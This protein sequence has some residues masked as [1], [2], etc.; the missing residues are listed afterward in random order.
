METGQQSAVQPLVPPGPISHGV[1]GA[2][3]G[4]LLF[5]AAG[6]GVLSWWL[7]QPPAPLPEDAPPEVFSAGRAMQHMRSVAKEPHAA[8]SHALAEVHAY[9][10]ATLRGYGLEVDLQQ[11]CEVQA[12]SMGAVE[13]IV[14]RI[15]G[16]PGGTPFVITTHYDSV[17]SGPG[18]A[19]D[20]SGTVVMLEAARAL[21][22]G[23]PPRNDIVFVFTCDE[24]RMQGGV[25]ACVDHPWVKDAPVVLGF[26]A[27]GVYGPA[28]MFETSDG[29]G[30]LIRALQESGADARTN[31]IMFEV[32]RRTPNSTDFAV[33]KGRGFTGYNVAFVG[34]LYYY[35]TMNDRPELVDPASIQQQGSYAMALARY[36]G[37]REEPVRREE[38]AVYFNTVGAHVVSYP[39]SWSLRIA[40]MAAFLFAAALML[41][42]ALR[43]LTLRGLLFSI[44]AQIAAGLFIAAVTGLLVFVTYKVFYVY[45]LYNVTWYLF[46]FLTFAFGVSAFAYGWAGKRTAP[47]NLHGGALLLWLAVLA[48]LE[49]A[50]PMASFF[51][52]WPLL[53]GSLSLC[54]AV[55]LRACGVGRNVTLPVQVVGA[56]P[57][58]LSLGPGL[59]MLHQIGAAFLLVP[60]TV[61]FFLALALLSPLLAVVMQ[62]RSR[63]VPLACCGTAALLMAIGWATNGFSPLAPKMT[64]LSYALD[65]EKGE[66][67]WLSDDPAPDAWT[68]QFFAHAAAEPTADEARGWARR[69]AGLSAPAPI[70][71]LEGPRL[72]VLGDELRGGGRVLT[73]RYTSPRKAPEAFFSVLPPTRVLAAECEGR[74]ISERGRKGLHFH[75]RVMPWSGAVHFQLKVEPEAAVRIRIEEVSFEIPGVEALGYTPRP[76]WMVVKAN[77]LEWWEGRWGGLSSGCTFVVDEFE[78]PARENASAP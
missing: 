31:S 72:D 53:F 69:G 76:D 10:V 17:H 45:L 16:Q 15:P 47:E 28:L 22:Q 13:N 6:L 48:G 39:A 23:P 11:L 30:A 12:H 33:L 54:F 65:L 29:N 56:A 36:F 8:G 73:L 2:V 4:A 63:R 58:L 18:A 19:D 34:G 55:W 20:G 64:S 68:G 78:I 59:Q 50:V 42:L 3:R 27:R 5:F 32:H 57:L 21:R 46:A 26:E 62:A 51:A 40:V 74:P 61:L 71:P 25:R 60:N 66:A 75:M 70:V 35:H 1:R 44:A 9:L 43:V 14:A 37:N 7:A 38:N 77:T 52:A 41:G 49:Y 24:E 67:I